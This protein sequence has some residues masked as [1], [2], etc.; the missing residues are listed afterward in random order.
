MDAIFRVEPDDPAPVY[1]QLERQI[2]VAVAA[3]TLQP[4]D[5]LPPVREAARRLGLSPNTVGRAYAD[6]SR[7]GVITA[8]AGGGSEIA[9]RDRL[10]QPALMRTRQERLRTLARQVAVRGLALGLEPSEIVDAVHRELT[11]QGRPVQDST[12]QHVDLGEAE[13]PLLSARNRLRGT[14]SSLRVGDVLAEVTLTLGD[15]TE[16]VAAVTRAS[17]ERLNLAVGVHVSAYVKATEL[18][19][20]R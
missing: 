20:G 4:G 11:Q 1:I 18:V 14:I 12:A 2:R 6:L 7:E 3:G 19:L 15:G 5:H 16:V 9:S 13:Q 10:N 8:R 17:V